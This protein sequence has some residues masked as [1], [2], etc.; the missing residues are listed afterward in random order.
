ML[1]IIFHEQAPRPTE[2]LNSMFKHNESIN[3]LNTTSMGYN[4]SPNSRIVLCC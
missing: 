1:P 2:R 3:S 4:A